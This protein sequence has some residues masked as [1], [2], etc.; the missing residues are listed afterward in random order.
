MP[1]SLRGSALSAETIVQ[2]PNKSSDLSIT[3]SAAF[4]VGTPR[5]VS[6]SNELFAVV[7]NISALHAEQPGDDTTQLFFSPPPHVVKGSRTLEAQT[8]EI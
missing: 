1:V 2:P 6:G 3:R 7:G 5:L 4:D 8:E